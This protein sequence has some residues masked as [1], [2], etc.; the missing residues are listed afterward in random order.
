MANNSSKMRTSI[1]ERRYFWKDANGKVI[2][3]E[4]QMFRR[5]ANAVAAAENKYKGTKNEKNCR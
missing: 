4:E 3:N 5:V 1:L 2:E